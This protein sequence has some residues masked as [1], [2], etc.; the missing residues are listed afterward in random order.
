MLFECIDELQQQQWTMSLLI[1]AQDKWGDTPLLLALKRRGSD[2]PMTFSSRLCERVS[3]TFFRDWALDP[4]LE[5]IHYRLPIECCEMVIEE[6]RNQDLYNVCLARLRVE[7]RDYNHVCDHCY[8]MYAH[9]GAD[10]VHAQSYRNAHRGATGFI[11]G[12]VHAPRGI[13]CQRALVINIYEC[14]KLPLQYEKII[15][16]NL[17]SLSV[18]RKARVMTVCGRCSSSSNKHPLHPPQNRTLAGRATEHKSCTHYKRSFSVHELTSELS[19]ARPIM[20]TRT[21]VIYIYI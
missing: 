3:R 2:T 21:C 12:R 15:V 16:R 4:F 5:L 1:D 17:S 9:C 10:V 11:T 20:C 18:S 14:T 8:F 19:L 7:A 13:T 6:L